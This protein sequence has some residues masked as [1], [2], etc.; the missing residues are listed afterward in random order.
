[1][2]RRKRPITQHM[3]EERRQRAEEMNKEYNE[4]YPTLQAKLAALPQGGANKQRARLVA[5]IE[6]EQAEKNAEKIVEQ[7]KVEAKAE[8]A[9]KK[10][11]KNQ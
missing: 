4:K 10:K 11:G 2:S 1:M 8:K 3:R 7:A 5:L 9:A 6:A